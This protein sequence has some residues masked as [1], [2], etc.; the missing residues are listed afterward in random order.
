MKEEYIPWREALWH[1]KGTG[2]VQSDDWTWLGPQMTEQ[3]ISV[4]LGRFG[5]GF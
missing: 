2:Q 1:Y 5:G 3:Q 4:A